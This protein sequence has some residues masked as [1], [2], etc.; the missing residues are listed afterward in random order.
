MI[1]TGAEGCLEV[2]RGVEGCLDVLRGALR[3]STVDTRRRA[4]PYLRGT[5]PLTPTR[6]SSQDLASSDHARS[7]STGVLRGDKH[8]GA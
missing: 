2:R 1:S 4:L 7:I 6:N 5:S 8:G 3:I